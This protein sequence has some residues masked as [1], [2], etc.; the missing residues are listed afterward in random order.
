MEYKKKGNERMKV[1]RTATSPGRPFLGKGA[2]K[3]LWSSSEFLIWQGGLEINSSSRWAGEL[4]AR[5]FFLFWK[6]CEG[7]NKNDKTAIAR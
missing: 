1:H 6:S 2:T 4:S 7:R 5:I 3:G